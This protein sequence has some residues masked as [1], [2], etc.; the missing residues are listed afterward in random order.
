MTMMR[1]GRQCHPS[2]RLVPV[3]VSKALHASQYRWLQ[4]EQACHPDL[5]TC[6]FEDDNEICMCVILCIYIYIYVCHTDIVSAVMLYKTCTI[7]YPSKWLNLCFSSLVRTSET[8]SATQGIRTK[9][10]VRCKLEASSNRPW[11]KH[12]ISN[13]LI[14]PDWSLISANTIKTITRFHRFSP[15][16]SV[17]VL[18]ESRCEVSTHIMTLETSTWIQL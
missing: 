16:K 3:K 18:H 10:S 15:I 9:G 2:N 14:I 13:H 11:H 8:S 6:S 5:Y 1:A 12:S 17:V 7:M 4:S